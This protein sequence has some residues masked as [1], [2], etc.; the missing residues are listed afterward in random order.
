MI[1]VVD[2]RHI[3]SMENEKKSMPFSDVYIGGAP[4]EILKSRLVYNHSKV[5]F[6]LMYVLMFVYKLHNAYNDVNLCIVYYSVMKTK[7]MTNY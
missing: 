2:R 7:Q 4:T 3:K 1:L 5:V 6:F